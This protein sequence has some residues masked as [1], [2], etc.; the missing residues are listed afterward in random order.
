MKAARVTARQP[1]GN[2]CSKNCIC[3]LRVA[4]WKGKK[5]EE[6]LLALK[7]NM[8][9]N[10]IEDQC[11][12][13]MR[14]DGGVQSWLLLHED[15]GTTQRRRL[16]SGSILG[17]EELEPVS[18]G[19]VGSIHCPLPWANT[20]EKNHGKLSTGLCK[21]TH[22]LSVCAALPADRRGFMLLPDR[23]C[24]PCLQGS[25]AEEGKATKCPGR[26]YSKVLFVRLTVLEEVDFCR[27]QRKAVLRGW[28]GQSMGDVAV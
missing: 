16:S 15:G 20:G 27:Q 22:C 1:N 9:K 18:Q 23:L 10:G 2:Q 17:A 21:Q 7:K 24:P 25:L 8:C 3:P 13:M 26:N 6:G 11:H 19:G 4:R 5:E 28:C 12:D 14:L